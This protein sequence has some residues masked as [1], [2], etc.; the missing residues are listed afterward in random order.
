MPR[1]PNLTGS[2]SKSLSSLLTNRPVRTGI[3][4]EEIATPQK[5]GIALK[6]QK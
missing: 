1:P 4:F 3:N 6:Y 2:A 5:D